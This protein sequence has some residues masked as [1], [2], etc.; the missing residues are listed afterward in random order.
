MIYTIWRHSHR[1]DTIC[2][3]AQIIFAFFFYRTEPFTWN[4][5][6]LSKPQ[7]PIWYAVT[8]GM[9]FHFLKGTHFD[10]VFEKEKKCWVPK[11]FEEPEE[12]TEEY[13]CVSCLDV[14]LWV[15]QKLEKKRYWNSAPITI[16]LFLE[17]ST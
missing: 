9:F 6:N 10:I 14:S 8:W 2:N 17:V 15:L 12:N 13:K 3:L 7:S 1:H 5:P 11:L 4:S 16:K